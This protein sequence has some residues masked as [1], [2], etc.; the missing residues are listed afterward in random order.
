MSKPTAYDLVKYYDLDFLNGSALE[1]ILLAT[2]NPNLKK[3]H[4]QKA[5]GYLKE[6]EKIKSKAYYQSQDLNLSEP[7][8]YAVESLLK[9]SDPSYII[10][11]LKLEL[12]NAVCDDISKTQCGRSDSD[13]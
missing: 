7:L 9:Q 5:I 4:L 3:I 8:T 6:R 12:A 10:E 2:Q 13:I 1:Q 11:K